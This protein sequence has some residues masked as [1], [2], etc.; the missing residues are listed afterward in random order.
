MQSATQQITTKSGIFARVFAAPQ[1]FD[2]DFALFQ[3]CARYGRQARAV[4]K[5]FN[6]FGTQD[7]P[8]ALEDAAIA[9]LIDAREQIAAIPA[10]TL[11]GLKAKALV[12]V[13][14]LES[15]NGDAG[16]LAPLLG[17]IC[18]DIAALST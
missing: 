15:S 7:P 9:A 6:Q 3:Q 8:F 17:S 1:R 13:A 4:E 12:A 16:D 18:D 14:E 11:T 5:M 2:A 10:K